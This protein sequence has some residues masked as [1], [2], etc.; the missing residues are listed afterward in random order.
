MLTK[1]LKQEHLN[2]IEFEQSLKSDFE[3]REEKDRMIADLQQKGKLEVDMDVAV[4]Q[5]AQDLKDA[6]KEEV[7]RFQ[8]SDR[9][10]EEDRKNDTTSL[11][12]KLE[13]TLVLLVE[14]QLGKE[15]HFLL[16]QGKREAGETMRQ[17]AERV[18][19]EQCGDGIEVTFYGNA[20]C[21]FYKYKYPK[22]ERTETVGAKIFFYRSM[23][24]SGNI[25]GANYEWLNKTELQGKVK[26]SY[27]SCVSQ[28]VL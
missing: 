12:R 5:T 2:Q 23:H 10:T 20:P 11:N 3:M 22:A 15:R 19:R 1:S 16:P 21:G 13:D 8:L 6:W 17:T 14:Q 7:G 9:V 24:K 28:L 18:L 27:S 26:P 4:Q 25:V